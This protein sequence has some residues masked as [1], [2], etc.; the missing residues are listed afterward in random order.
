MGLGGLALLYA[1][2]TTD[3]IGFALV[4]VALAVHIIR[5]RRGAAVPAQA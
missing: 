3:M 4:L 1:S 5:T 2:Q